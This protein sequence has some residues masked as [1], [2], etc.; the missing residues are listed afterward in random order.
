MKK[1]TAAAKNRLPTAILLALLLGTC[2]SYDARYTP[3]SVAAPPSLAIAACAPARELTEK[4]SHA[5]GV[6][7]YKPQNGYDGGYLTVNIVSR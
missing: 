3:A 6:H 4:P 2:A 1:D 5:G 7:G